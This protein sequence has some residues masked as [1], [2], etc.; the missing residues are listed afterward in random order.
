MTGGTGCREKERE[1]EKE[2]ERAIQRKSERNSKKERTKDR[3]IHMDI[4][5]VVE[6][7]RERW[8]DREKNERGKVK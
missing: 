8:M 6:V 3:K 2:T 5:R 4:D 1:M 7:I